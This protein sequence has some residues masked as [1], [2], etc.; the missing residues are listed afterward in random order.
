FL[1]IGGDIW[2]P[3][4]MP[5]FMGCDVLSCVVNEPGFRV[6]DKRG[7]TPVRVTRRKWISP[8][9]SIRVLTRVNDVIE[10]FYIEHHQLI[11]L[12]ISYHSLYDGSLLIAGMW[13]PWILQPSTII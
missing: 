2:R 5:D 11:G 3:Q 12:Q 4:I 1:I 13:R 7:T 8:C 9:K 10:G 6:P